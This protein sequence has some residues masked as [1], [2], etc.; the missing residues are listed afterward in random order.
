MK[1]TLIFA[2]IF[3]LATFAIATCN[4]QTKVLLKTYEMYASTYTDTTWKNGPMSSVYIDALFV[5]DTLFL[6]NEPFYCNNTIAVPTG[7][8]FLCT[9]K[10]HVRCSV[11]LL[12]SDGA[13]ILI[14]QYQRIRWI[15]HL[16]KN[17]PDE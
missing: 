9:D 6:D 8:T 17:K 2:I 10:Q 11:S 15:Y 1:K 14:L 4:A 5:D 3:A 13:M 16:L 7:Y 12:V